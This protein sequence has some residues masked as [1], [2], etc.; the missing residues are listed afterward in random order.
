MNYLILISG[1]SL[2]ALLSHW[3]RKRRKRLRLNGI[4][5]RERYLK[6]KKELSKKIKVDNSKYG[7]RWDPTRVQLDIWEEAEK[8][9]AMNTEEK[10]AYEEERER[11]FVEG[12]QEARKKELKKFD[13][14][15]NIPLTTEEKKRKS[16]IEEA[17]ERNK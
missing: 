1:I 11:K 9:M 5:E 10:K 8:V 7:L 15:D 3:L 2:G 16:M 12:L 4:R 6:E 13:R 14:G 17:I